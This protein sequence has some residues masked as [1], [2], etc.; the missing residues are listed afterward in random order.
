MPKTITGAIF[1]NMD[2][3]LS[4]FSDITSPR[5]VPGWIMRLRPTTSNTIPAGMLRRPNEFSRVVCAEKI[6]SERHAHLFLR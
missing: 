6:H 4:K 3:R 1:P 2:F 5:T